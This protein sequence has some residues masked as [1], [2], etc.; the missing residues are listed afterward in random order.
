MQ[1]FTLISNEKKVIYSGLE[2]DFYDFNAE[3]ILD[4]GNIITFILSKLDTDFYELETFLSKKTMLFL[5]ENSYLKEYDFE[6][7]EYFGQWGLGVEYV[8][9]SPYLVLISSGEARKGVYKCYV[10]A[11]W[12]SPHV[13]IPETKLIELNSK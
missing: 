3:I 8:Y 7:K 6:D 13:D 4:D 5:A 12:Y 1:E 9:R 2:D 11:I 10:E